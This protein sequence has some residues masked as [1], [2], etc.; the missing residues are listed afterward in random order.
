LKEKHNIL[1]YLV[2]PRGAA[3]HSVVIAAIGNSITCPG[4]RSAWPNSTALQNFL[5]TYGSS[6][7]SHKE[8]VTYNLFLK[9]T[10]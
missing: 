5:C 7:H 9:G 4:C 1:K 2:P 3:A 8:K 6:P 10:Q